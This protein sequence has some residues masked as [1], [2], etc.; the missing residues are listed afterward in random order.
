MFLLC[1]GLGACSKEILTHKLSTDASPMNG[2]T[3]SPPSNSYEHGQQVTLTATPVGEYLFKEW[4]G[5]VTGSTNPTNV[6]M[7]ADKQV[8]GVFEKRQYP[9]TLTIE[10]NGTVKEEVIAVAS[11]SQYPSGT[12]VRLTALP[13]DG[14][15]FKDW[16]GDQNSLTNPLDLKIDKPIILKASFL[17]KPP[18]IPLEFQSFSQVNK[19][20]SY[21]ATLESSYKSY[22]NFNKFRQFMPS[23]MNL[24]EP[25]HLSSAYAFLDFDKDGDSDF[26]FASTSYTEEHKSIYVI[27]NKG[28]N[29]W[30]LFK[31]LPGFIWPRKGVL[32][33]V[34]KNGYLDFIVADQGYD[35]PPYPGAEIGIVYFFKDR[36]EVK[37]IPNSLAYNHTISAADIDND[38]D[39]DLVTVDH[40]YRNNNGEFV[41]EDNLSVQQQNGYYH[42]EL[43]D[44]NQDGNVDLIAGNAENFV[45]KNGVRNYTRVFW[46]KGDGKF[47]YDNA[48]E[49]PIAGGDDTFGMVDD[50]DFL[51]F[52]NDGKLDLIINRGVG[53]PGA[54]GYYIQFLQNN[55]DRTFKEVTQDRIDNYKFTTTDPSKHI[56]FVWIRLL[57]LNQDGKLDMIVREGSPPGTVPENE[58]EWYWMNDGT[59]HFKLKK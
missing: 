47:R 6:V 37:V 44:L 52:N 12:S 34:D 4:K 45:N 22:E 28:N 29:N 16:S 10:G 18:L 26:I 1:L 3:V 19:T 2:G 57:D 31:K 50:F 9:L 49:L 17:V 51:D 30:A 20:N 46:N 14:Y 5:S 13:G 38:G 27:E 48:T 39:I 55:G 7:D 43:M 59:N 40:V 21:F 54:V 8:T 25:E 23:A 11:Q 58:K 24:K 35:Y 32:A 42:L 15:V 53:I 33:D 36:V 41:R 56:W